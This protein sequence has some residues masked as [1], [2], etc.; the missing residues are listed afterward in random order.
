VAILDIAA[1]TLGLVG[2]L[3]IFLLASV[4]SAT[5]RVPT[6]L[7]AVDAPLLVLGIVT[8]AAGIYAIQAKKWGLVLAGSI[9]ALLVFPLAGIPAITLAVLSKN[10]FEQSHD[11]A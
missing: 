7:I 11:T 2:G 9:S 3:V 8:F 6:V 4:G 5:F 1:G 10:E